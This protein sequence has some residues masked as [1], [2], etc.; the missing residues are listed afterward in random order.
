MYREE[1]MIMK[2]LQSDFK[3]GMAKVLI[4]TS[5]DLWYLF[6]LVL[7]GDK[8]SGKTM[9]KV[10]I[11]R[12]DDRNQKI[13]KKPVAITIRAEKVDFSRTQHALRIS[14][15]V[16]F[17]PDDVAKGSYHTFN[18]EENS[19][20]AIEKSHWS[21]Y[22]I[23][24]LKESE[25]QRTNAILLVVMDREEAIVAELKRFGYNLLSRHH[26][27]AAKKTDREHQASDFYRE[28]EHVLADYDRTRS[29]NHII[30][31]SPAFFKEDFIKQ[32]H[33]EKLKEKIILATVSSCSQNAFD[34]LL[35]RKEVEQA[36]HDEQVAEE[37]KLVEALLVEI[38][39]ERKGGKAA[40][41]LVE[42]EKKVYANAVKTLVLT[43]AYI[44]SE[45]EKGNFDRIENIIRI[46]EQTGATVRIISSDH[47]GGAK[48]DGIGG[49]AA[50]L[51]YAEFG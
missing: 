29:P 14:G 10:K 42:V 19:I 39:K 12:E 28:F 5:D 50:M 8:I 34:E 36:L 38:A 21:P 32:M 16:V 4:E 44:R 31:A 45:R 33:D 37:L 46:V 18:V 48:L 23:E 25:K 2:L 24:K 47:D 7:P 15:I 40:Y 17:G 3:H 51:H 41:G 49:I 22:Q 11:G 26:G 27:S 35:K 20:L 43:N 13:I 9:R 1:W 6:H 30:V